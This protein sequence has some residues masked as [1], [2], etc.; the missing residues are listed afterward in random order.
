MEPTPKMN[1]DYFG[2]GD[3]RSNP[4]KGIYYVRQGNYPYALFL[5]GHQ[6]DKMGKLFDINNEGRTLDQMYPKYTR[7]VETEG[8]ENAD[9]YK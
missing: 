2:K 7:W 6:I 4:A 1:Y 5:D 3:D 9:W 8:M